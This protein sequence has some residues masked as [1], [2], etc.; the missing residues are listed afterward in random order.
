MNTYNFNDDSFKN[1]SLYQN[2]IAAN[3][4]IGYLKVRASAAS[5]AL[6]ISGLKIVVS[7]T[8]DN[9][10]VIFFEGTTNSSGVIEKI[11]LPAPKQNADDLVAPSS[12]TYD[13][14]A[15]Y[16]P[17]NLNDIYQVNIY[18]NIYVLQRINIV[19]TLNVSTGDDRW[20]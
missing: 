18:E 15:T 17:D 20:L 16:E 10:R 13:I 1:T 11:T 2:F 7:K 3:P 12:T 6:P 9:N 19:P 14:Y 4:S 8:I 5:Q